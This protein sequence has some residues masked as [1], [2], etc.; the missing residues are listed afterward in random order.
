VFGKEKMLGTGMA[1]LPILGA[2]RDD[3][4]VA[5]E[6]ASYEKDQRAFSEQPAWR[7]VCDCICAV[8]FASNQV[9]KIPP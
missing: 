4:A 7:N 6:N 8:N 1:T 3:Y 5:C 2:C 9:L